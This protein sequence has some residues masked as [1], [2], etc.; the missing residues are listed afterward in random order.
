MCAESHYTHREANGAASAESIEE[1]ERMNVWKLRQDELSATEYDNELLQ[2]YRMAFVRCVNQVYGLHAQ[3]SHNLNCDVVP[4]GCNLLEYHDRP[5]P[6]R[7]CTLQ[8]Q[9]FT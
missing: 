7:P 2:C 9:Q 3:A 8:Y 5:V 6:L 4:N 1:A